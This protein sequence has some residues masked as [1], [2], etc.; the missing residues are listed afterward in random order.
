MSSKYLRKYVSQ[1]ITLLEE[2]EEDG[3]PPEEVLKEVCWKLDIPFNDSISDDDDEEDDST[4]EDLATDL[5][6]DLDDLPKDD[7]DG[8]EE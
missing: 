7:E 1:F 2:A 4:I 3:Y 6:L 5:D 8:E